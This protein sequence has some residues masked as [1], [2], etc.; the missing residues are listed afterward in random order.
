MG[1]DTGRPRVASVP[2]D[3]DML[4]DVSD[5]DPPTSLALARSGDRRAWDAIVAAYSPL[6]WAVARSFRLNSADAA[7][8]YQATWLR[9]VENLN[10][11]R[12]G[13]RLGA[14]LSTTARREA[15]MLLRRDRRQ[16][17]VA[18]VEL[19]AAVADDLSPAVEAEL[20]RQEEQAGLW[21]AFRLLSENCQRLLRVIF[22][23]PPPSYAELSSALD[24]PIGSIGPT[25]SRCL[26][27][28][29]NLLTGA[30]KW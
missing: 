28:L 26:G 9:L 4:A 19:L 27:R 5:F 15:L 6:V 8:V 3:I 23:D 12:D 14:W 10:R 2:I 29:Q 24:M 21:Q 22:T 7:D 30:A 20:L 13:D 18:S 1:T 11:V 17:T 16:A 25:R